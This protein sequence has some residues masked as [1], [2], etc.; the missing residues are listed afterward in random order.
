MECGG[1]GRSNLVNSYR[2]R[3]LR[4]PGAAGERTGTEG[5]DGIGDGHGCEGRAAGE[6]VVAD[7]Y[8]AFGQGHLREFLSA[9]IPWSFRGQSIIVSLSRPGGEHDGCYAPATTEFT[10]LVQTYRDCQGGEGGATL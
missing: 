3:D 2:N 7:G 5:C 4:E 10:G 6:R 1:G 8:D 9:E